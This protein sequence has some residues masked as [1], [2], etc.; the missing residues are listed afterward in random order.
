MTSI[1][2]M[3][4]AIDMEWG[5][6]ELY[7][8]TAAG[9]LPPGLPHTDPKYYLGLAAHWAKAYMTGP[10]AG[11]DTLNLYDVSGLAHYELHHAITQA[12]DPAVWRSPKP[13]S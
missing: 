3:S 11:A 8:A 12:G 6:T 2:K 1:L 4:G 9:A 13:I 5:A 7:F 10:F